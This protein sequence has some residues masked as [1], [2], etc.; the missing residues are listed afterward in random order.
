MLMSP[1]TLA[2]L[3]CTQSLPTT[4]IR[5]STYTYIYAIAVYANKIFIP[6]YIQITHILRFPVWKGTANELCVFS[7]DFLIALRNRIEQ[8]K[9]SQIFQFV[10]CV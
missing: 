1:L 9:F 7:G 3:G 10:Y 2:R 8:E 6:D 4:T 5:G